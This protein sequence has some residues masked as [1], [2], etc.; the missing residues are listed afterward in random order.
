MYDILS[1]TYSSFYLRVKTRKEGTQRS[2]IRRH[3]DLVDDHCYA[4]CL[5]AELPPR[6]SKSEVFFHPID[7]VVR[8]LPCNIDVT[9][10]AKNNTLVPIKRTYP[11]A[12][13]PSIAT[14]SKFLLN[15]SCG[16]APL[17]KSSTIFD[18]QQFEKCLTN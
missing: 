5:L 13:P 2:G 6:D 4:S 17:R 10:G 8:R 11:H 14:I 1:I 12:S 3:V 9:L 16:S 15:Y 7:S 18:G